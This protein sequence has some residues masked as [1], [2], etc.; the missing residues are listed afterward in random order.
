MARK[1]W[2]YNSWYDCVGLDRLLLFTYGKL[3][4]W[5]IYFLSTFVV[6]IIIVLFWTAVVSL[7]VTSYPLSSISFWTFFNLFFEPDPFKIFIFI[8]LEL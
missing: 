6:F 4:I 5:L 3:T 1:T 8:N 2:C 7:V